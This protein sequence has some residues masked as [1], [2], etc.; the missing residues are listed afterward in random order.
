MTRA[1][2]KR[3]YNSTAW[4]HK[5]QEILEIGHWECAECK[6]QGKVTTQM[7]AILDIDHIQDLE[8]HPELALDNDNLQILC[9]EHHNKKH[10][11]Y[12]K[13]KPKEKNFLINEEYFFEN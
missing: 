10:D 6:R 8:H 4:K 13:S 9:R 2:R 1:E 3:F 11:K 7:D 12:F 5:R